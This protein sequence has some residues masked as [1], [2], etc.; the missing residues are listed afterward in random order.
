MPQ[1]LYYLVVE[2]FRFQLSIMKLDFKTSD[3]SHKLSFYALKVSG[4]AF[5]SI[6]TKPDNGFEFFQ[7]KSDYVIFLVSFLFSLLAF[8]MGASSI[9]NLRLQ[10]PVMNMGTPMIWRTSMFSFL[11]T[12]IV[13]ISNARKTFEIMQNL[14]W[15]DRQV[16]LKINL[17]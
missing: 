3:V 8:V 17:I 2:S 14:Q 4:Y 16:F 13:F 7:S 10:S 1:S 12:K 6:K 5:F 9:I 11:V 15:M